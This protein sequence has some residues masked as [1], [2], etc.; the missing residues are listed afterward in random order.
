MVQQAAVSAERSVAVLE[1]YEAGDLSGALA[2]LRN[3]ELGESD[4]EALTEV[5]RRVLLRG[6][7]DEAISILEDITLRVPDSA[8]TYVRLGI[9][10]QR[11]GDLNDARN[12]F[13]RA[14]EIQPDLVDAHHGLGSATMA[15][16][17][18]AEALVHL[19]HAAE[20][21]PE[22][23]A[24]QNEL[25]GAL[26]SLRRFDEAAAAF[27][28]AAAAQPEWSVP[29]HNLS[30][31]AFRRGD[32][33]AAARLLRRSTEI[34]SPRPLSHFELGTLLLQ[35]GEFHEGWREYEWRW[36]NGGKPPQRPDLPVPVWDGSPLG[37]R[38]LLLW[39]EQ[40]FGDIL[41]F[42]RFA[43]LI[44]K[45]QGKVFLHA[46]RKLMSLLATCPGIDRV[47]TDGE[48]LEIDLQFPVMSLPS[49]FDV[50]PSP[51]P[52]Y[53][54]GRADCEDA[55]KA[56]ERGKAFNVGIVWASGRLYPG[57]AARDCPLE[58][59]AKLADIPGVRLYSLQY[60]D[61]AGALA[62]STAPIVDLSP[63]LG[64]FHKTAA[65]V[66][67]LDLVIT[68]DSS[69]AHLAGALGV[70]VWTLIGHAP[71]WRWMLDRDDSPW[72]G[73]MRLYR[74][75]SAGDWV[76]VM[77]R[78]AEDLR[79]L[80]GVRF[81]EVAP[82][83][84]RTLT[85]K[86]AVPDTRVFI[87]QYGERRT[88]TNFVRASLSANYAD[89]EV[90][91]HVLGDKHSPPAPLDDLR[92]EADS[93]ADPAWAFVSAATFGVPAAST[94]PWN[95][96][97]QAEVRRLAG[98]VMDAFDRGVLRYVISIKDPYAW[99]VS[100]AR[101]D[102]WVLGTMPLPPDFIDALG[103]ACRRFNRVYA[104]WLALADRHPHRVW[105]V[106]YEELLRD[107]DAVLGAIGKRFGLRRRSSDWQDI[108]GDVIPAQWDGWG[109]TTSE[110]LFDREYYL[111]QRYLDRIPDEHR[112]IIAGTIDWPLFS[113]F[114]Y[115]PLTN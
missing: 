102:R 35:E 107:A 72:Y 14:V 84:R 15:M 24:V 31:I 44:P 16:G 38:V 69:P 70:P 113:R 65:F 63:V 76:P 77:Q 105:L 33:E 94:Q 51:I 19:H 11:R 53:L 88:G 109:V 93:Q 99:A 8:V 30:V 97:Q 34:G 52:P 96:D 49:L 42:I 48:E 106:S 3:F 57:H 78:I 6:E 4:V 71:D 95:Q 7:V 56:I 108:G 90:L 82:L 18:V 74:Q 115:E 89:V 20:L 36:A 80:A 55:E 104:A 25:G 27:E 39:H 10:H 86:A 17:N 22:S 73:S 114:G 83:P 60:G 54:D 62:D 61:A 9:T 100:I 43:S 28:R 91:M 68:I 87:K 41:Q 59:F 21:D 23:A 46:P 58:L 12:A 26:V 47:V 110:T 37:E 32:R 50:V 66:K 111:E 85:R 29:V 45:E 64:D 1:L 2:A 40:G 81:S 101:M 79:A 92:R 13:R 103:K 75:A 112:R 5:A 98:A 67:R